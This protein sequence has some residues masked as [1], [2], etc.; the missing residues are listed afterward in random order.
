[1]RTQRTLR[2]SG[3]APGDVS[4]HA[5][6]PG[7]ADSAGQPLHTRVEPGDY[8]HLCSDRARAR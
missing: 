3:P 4:D 6:E 1:M 2:A 7:L 5:T 8:R